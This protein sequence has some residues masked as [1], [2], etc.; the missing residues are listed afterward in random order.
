MSATNWSDFDDPVMVQ[1][2]GVGRTQYNKRRTYAAH[3]RQWKCTKL[4]EEVGY[5]LR[6]G[7]QS[8]L[9]RR[10]GVSRSTICR[11][12]KLTDEAFRRGT[13]IETEEHYRRVIANF[14]R[15]ENRR[16]ARIFEGS[17]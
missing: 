17:W 12:F 2:R 9:A 8:D 13:S 5:P 15:Q 6:R 3:L 1:K 7:W 16:W 11:D 10:M 4:L 14:E